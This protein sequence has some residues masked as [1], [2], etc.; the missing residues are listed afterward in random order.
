MYTIQEMVQTDLKLVTASV[1]WNGVRLEA[2]LGSSMHMCVPILHC[3]HEPWLCLFIVSF[4]IY[5]PPAEWKYKCI[6]MYTWNPQ[7]FGHIV[8]RN[9]IPSTGWIIVY[10]LSPPNRLPACVRTYTCTCTCVC[11][12]IGDPLLVSI[13]LLSLVEASFKKFDS[14]ITQIRWESG[15]QSILV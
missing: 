3:F 5:I 10:N 11:I 13:R 15:T 12:V 4:S 14:I 8:L 9:S 6:Y 2:V 1:P 7:G